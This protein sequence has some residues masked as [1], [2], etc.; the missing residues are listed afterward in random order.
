Q[1]H[2]ERLAKHPVDIAIVPLL[3]SPAN[4]CRSLLRFLELG[5]YGIPAVYSNVGEYATHLKSE[6]DGLAVGETTE[7]WLDALRTL[8]RNRELRESIADHAR[9]T[10]EESWTIEKHIEKYRNVLSRVGIGTE[11]KLKERGKLLAESPSVCGGTEGGL[12]E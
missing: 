4:R 11:G 10:V 1:V 5:W 2:L 6:H 3:D 12:L 9:R 8:C 7:E